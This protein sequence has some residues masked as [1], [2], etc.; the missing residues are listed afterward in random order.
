MNII[1]ATLQ[2]PLQIFI[3]NC[4]AKIKFHLKFNKM[5]IIISFSI[6]LRDFEEQ[7]SNV[8]LDSELFYNS[9]N[10]Y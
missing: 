4:S 9:E 3:N 5:F 6:Y 10:M 8:M 7:F 2:S 1:D